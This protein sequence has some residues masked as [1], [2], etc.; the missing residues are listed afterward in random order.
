[1]TATPDSQDI[2]FISYAS[3]DKTDA[4]AVVTVL[5][6]SGLPCWIAPRDIPGGAVWAE[7][8]PDAISRCHLF[9]LVFSAASDKSD[10]VFRELGLAAHLKKKIFPVR[11]RPDQPKRTVFF[12]ES[13]HWFNGFERP[14]GTYSAELVDAVQQRISTEPHTIPDPGPRPERPRHNG[15]GHPWVNSGLTVA[16][17]A[18]AMSLLLQLFFYAAGITLLQGAAYWLVLAVCALIAWGMQ[19]LWNSFKRRKESPS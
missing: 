12:L 13:V 15:H 17:I 6:G 2:V 4:D 9:L 11:I 19:H 16:A 8:I 10:D 14:L 7:A 1:V 5:E 3:V 18:V